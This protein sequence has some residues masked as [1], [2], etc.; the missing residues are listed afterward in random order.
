MSEVFKTY[1]FG[2][3]TDIFAG[4]DLPD[5]F[6]TEKTDLL[7]IPVFSNGEKNNGL[8][9][10]TDIP[11]V[12]KPAVTISARGSKVG[13]AALRK[14]P[15]LPIVRLLSLIPYEDKLDVNFL[16]Y[17]LKLNRLGGTGSGQPQITIPDISNRT[18]SVPPLH[19]QQK[20]A[21][22]LS[23]LDS[24]IEL[25]NRVNAELE[26]MAK[27]IYEYW[28]VQFDFPISKEQAKAMGK[29]K[30]EGKSYKVSG[31]KM[32][33]SEELKR[34]IPQCFKEDFLNT[35]A[36]TG[37][38]GTPKS[39][40]SSYYDGGKIPWI[41]S[42]EVN[43]PFIVCAEKFITEEGL[44]NSSAK[45]FPKGTI[46]MAM[47]G[48][49]AGKVSIIDIEASTNQAICAVMPNDQ[50]FTWYIKFTLENLY[51]YLVNLSS[52]SA[53]DN[54][55]QDKIRGL[56]FA[57][58]PE[59]VLKTFHDIVNPMMLKVLANLKENL[60][61]SELRDWL[62]PMLMNGQVKIREAAEPKVMKQV[63]SESKPTNSYFYQTQL[64][65]AIVNASKKHKI[66][67]GEMTL[68][69]YTYLADKLYGVPTYFNY[70]RLHLGPYPK[71]MKKIVNNK[72]FF[73]IQ[74]N[75]VSVVPQEKEY[76]YQF[77]KQVEEAVAEL[78]SIFNQ[79]KGQERSRQTEL[80]ATVCKAVEDIK[81]T[82]LE[83]VRES[84]K[85]W[86][87]DLKT[88]KFKNKAEK[89]GEEETVH[90]LRAIRRMNWERTLLRNN[91]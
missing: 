86:P 23:V 4:G 65:A 32:V 41:N 8:Y 11:K 68:A 80:L 38:G 46:L 59:N 34:E 17:N 35:I 3:I 48:A 75:E 6:S 39:T 63:L 13:F 19:T 33:W 60:A 42:G 51:K 18:I 29:P 76:N 56:R 21:N 52:G 78:A 58:P 90:C 25:N 70:E 28:F 69:K 45:L 64:V 84:M 53:R 43:Q 77:Q 67:H 27:T 82:D 44:K 2:E 16:F 12:T 9:G 7:T 85:N 1:K 61:L 40:E 5:S 87:I 54:L 15:F 81:S 83:A 31:G 71:E 49:T 91:K 88:S 72:K 36:R 26:A 14:Q 79:Y 55:S 66:T 22:V 57:V 24:K 73:K 20:I 74:N 10:Y 50:H 62:L 89:F 30:L 37:S 47:Y